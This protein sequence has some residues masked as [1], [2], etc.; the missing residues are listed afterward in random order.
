MERFYLKL[1]NDLEGELT[2]LDPTVPIQAALESHYDHHADPTATGAK[3]PWV[4][5]CES[6]QQQQQQQQR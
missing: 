4:M 3:S 6:L 2:D 5:K 1:V